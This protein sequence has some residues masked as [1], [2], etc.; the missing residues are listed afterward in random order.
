MATKSLYSSRLKIALEKLFQMWISLWKSNPSSAMSIPCSRRIPV[1]DLEIFDHLR[2]HHPHPH[3]QRRMEV[4]CLIGRGE[5]QKDAARLA[6]V[7]LETV[8]SYCKVYFSGGVEALKQENWPGKVNEMDQHKQTLEE[9][10]K[11][12]PPRTVAEAC[13]R[14]RALTGL[15]RKPTQVRS[16]LKKALGL[17]SSGRAPSRCRQK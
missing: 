10:F 17:S 16:F 9:A 6:G 12:S 14:I 3:V 1:S 8:K 7:S 13:E 2:Y 11:A 15:E 4:M 5:F